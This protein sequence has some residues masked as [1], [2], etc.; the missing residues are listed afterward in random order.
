MLLFDELRDGGRGSAVFNPLQALV[1]VS[2]SAQEAARGRCA[3]MSQRF[4]LMGRF[5]AP[6]L[7]PAA[8]LFLFFFFF[9]LRNPRSVFTSVSLCSS[10]SSR[11]FGLLLSPGK[12]VKN[13]DMHLLD[14]V[15]QAWVVG[16]FFFP[17]FFSLVLV[18][19]PAAC[20]LADRDS[21]RA[22]FSG[23]DGKELRREVLH[24]H[25]KLEP[26]HASVPGRQRGNAQ[27]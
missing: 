11:C 13:S 12:N 15:S 2:G 5:V 9:H 18:P 24:H 27:R 4:D 7:F 25:G 14:L 26:Q 20:S 1:C 21:T 19:L 22:S 17:P 3:T 16:G 10:G 23:I 6:R 8:P